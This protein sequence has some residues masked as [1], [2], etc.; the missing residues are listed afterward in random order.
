ML[1]LFFRFYN[2][3]NIS[4]FWK[5]YV[6]LALM[7]VSSF[8]VQQTRGNGLFLKIYIM[9]KKTAIALDCFFMDM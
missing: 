6:L 4:F 2:G 7:V 5:T 9:L 1:Q 8:K 3:F